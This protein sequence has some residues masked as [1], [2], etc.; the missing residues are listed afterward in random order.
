M[1]PYHV[2]FHTPGGWKALT[3]QAGFRVTMQRAIRFPFVDMEALARR[4]CF[5]GMGVV[6]EAVRV[7]DPLDY[8]EV[9]APCAS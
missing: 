8:S 4:L 2:T 5:F 6:I 9:G 3:E 1:N 7:D